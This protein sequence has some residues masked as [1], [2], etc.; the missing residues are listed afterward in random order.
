M[1][2]T[3]W[4]LFLLKAADLQNILKSLV[5]NISKYLVKYYIIVARNIKHYIV[6][7]HCFENRHFAFLLT[8]YSYN[9]GYCVSNAIYYAK[10]NDVYQRFFN[11]IKGS[12]IIDFSTKHNLTSIYR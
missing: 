11:C 9:N 7:L 6:S 5:T 1:C 10:K 3:S 2:I 8:G 12:V 4:P